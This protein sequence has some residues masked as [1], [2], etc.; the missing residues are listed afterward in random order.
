M[1][2]PTLVKVLGD[3]L[4]NR[5]VAAPRLSGGLIFQFKEA[6]NTTEENR[7]ACY[8]I[9]KAPSENEI[10]TVER[11]LQKLLPFGTRITR[12]GRQLVYVGS[13]GLERTG[14]VLRWKTAVPRPDSF[15]DVP[16][17]T[18]AAGA[19]EGSG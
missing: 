16:S 9:G 8:R 13:D 4:N 12:Q 5:G 18:A 2:A 7:L 3:L 14:T 10:E 15:L 6:D 17:S 19:F 11:Y 1:A